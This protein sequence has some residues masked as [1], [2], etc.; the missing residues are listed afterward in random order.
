MYDNQTDCKDHIETK[1]V[2]KVV[3]KLICNLELFFIY[4]TRC[5][6]LLEKND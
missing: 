3:K 2:T 5:K 1:I 6:L 4:V